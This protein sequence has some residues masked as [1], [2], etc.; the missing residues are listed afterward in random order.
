MQLKMCL[1]F[2]GFCKPLLF[3]IHLSIIQLT[4]CLK[5]FVHS[6]IFKSVVK[7]QRSGTCYHNTFIDDDR[8]N[9]QA[10]KTNID[11]VHSDK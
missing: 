11:E 9:R 8:A 4:P 7:T 1:Q 2:F 6:T 3:D 5:L 10:D